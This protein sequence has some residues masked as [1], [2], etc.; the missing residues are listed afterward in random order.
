MIALFKRI[1]LLG[2]AVLALAS[3]A[4]APVSVTV[5]PSDIVCQVGETAKLTASVLPDNAKYDAIIWT[6]SNPTVASVSH[7]TVQALSAGTAVITAKAGEVSGTCSVTVNEPE[8]R[9]TGVTLEP[10][11]LTIK[12]G[13]HFALTATVSPV[14]ATNKNCIF[15]SGDNDVATISDDGVVEG[16][17]V[18][19][20]SVVAITE[21]GLFM[22]QCTVT[23]EPDKI[24]VTGVTISPNKTSL[25]LGENMTVKIAI[26]PADATD[27]SVTFKSSNTYVATVDG[28]GY[29]TTTG[30]GQTV[31]T[32][33]TNDGG[34]TDEC[35][36]SVLTVPEGVTVS[37]STLKLAEGEKSQLSASVAPSTAS[38][39]VE[40]ASSDTGIATVDRDGLVTAVS[41][42]TAKIYARS[43]THT[44]LQGYCEVEVTPDSSLK[45]IS[46]DET[47]FTVKIG[48]T[49]KLVVVYNPSYATNKNVSWTSLDEDVATVSDEGVVLGLKEG[50]TVVTATSE[51]GG[52]TASCIVT[53]NNDVTSRIYYMTGGYD[54]LYL[55]GEK[56]P[57]SGAFDKIDYEALTRFE[58]TGVN[59]ID[60]YGDDLY[61][62][63]KYYTKYGGN[64][65][66]YYVCKNRK[67]LFELTGT[68]GYSVYSF[69]AKNGYCAI[70]FEKT[71]SNFMLCKITPEGQITTCDLTGSFIRATVSDIAISPDGRNVYVASNIIDN[72]GDEYVAQYKWDESGAL[73]ETL[74]LKTQIG[75]PRVDVTNNG[76]VYVANTK[77]DDKGQQEAAIF[78]NGVFDYAFDKADYNM[79]VALMAKGN[80]LYTAT[81]N[82]PDRMLRLRCDYGDL[83]E[84][85]LDET[86]TFIRQKPLFVSSSGKYYTV[87]MTYTLSDFYI[88]ENT[89]M[90]RHIS[91]QEIKGLV[92]ID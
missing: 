35:L 70:L 17:S 40:W 28:D 64:K 78:R 34:F 65:T 57:L 68:E 8:V 54:N 69:D 74:I 7:G 12:V 90:L 39:D 37:P 2:A 81:I 76:D 61:S 43:V 36:L 30:Y 91:G 6:S 75:S 80:Y 19:V 49:H 14:N 50:N 45:G 38:Q 32:V 92:V 71:A 44:H 42:G 22:D 20:V 87:L 13:E 58:F 41:P 15:K 55:N 4:K 46:F 85:K 82:G 5:S 67:P 51:E 89:T 16:V 59:A 56:D 79:D 10:K 25:Y 23:V 3:C 53:V 18:G 63:E 66:Y 52:F 62:I 33:T 9:V 72:F 21:D 84:V 73:T 88:Y 77:Y 86:L 48:E 29:V 24:S 26:S 60:V 1:L 27:Q 83:K 11:K 47:A 31:I